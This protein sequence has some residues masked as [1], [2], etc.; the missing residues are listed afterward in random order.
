MRLW[1][2]IVVLGTVI[3]VEATDAAPPWLLLAATATGALCIISWARERL[4]RARKTRS[5]RFVGL[6]GNTASGLRRVRE[7]AESRKDD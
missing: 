6:E 7:A 4:I 1:F 3:A 2:G 5:A